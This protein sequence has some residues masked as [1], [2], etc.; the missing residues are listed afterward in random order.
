VCFRLDRLDKIRIDW[1]GFD[2]STP[3]CVPRAGV[4][5]RL[6]R[7]DKIRIDWI[8]FDL[9]TPLCVLRAGA[10]ISAHPVWLFCSL[11]ESE[12]WG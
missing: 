6:D 5:F 9:S 11:E 3:L 7:L 2:L 10:R 4:C 1:I 12:G 8:G